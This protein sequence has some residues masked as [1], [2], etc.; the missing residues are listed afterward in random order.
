MTADTA[1]TKLARMPQARLVDVARVSGVSIATVSRALNMPDLVSESTRSLIREAISSL[2]YVPNG[3]ART[4]AS[5]R[6]RTIG[7]IIPTIR[8]TTAAQTIESFER[9]LGA[10]GYSLL[11]AASESNSLRTFKSISVMIEKSVDAV[12]II[13]YLNDEKCYEAL[14]RKGIP[15]IVAGPEPERSDIPHVTYNHR[16]AALSI[17]DHLLEE[18]HRDFALILSPPAESVRLRERTEALKTR[19]SSLGLHLPDNRIV[20]VPGSTFA[21]GRE[22]LRF[23][24]QQGPF[25]TAIIASND[26]LAAGAVFECQQ[27]GIAVPQRVSIAG[28]GDA[29]V[30]SQMHPKLTTIRPPRAEIGELA[31]RFLLDKLAGKHPNLP[32]EL[33]VKFLTG[34][35]TGNVPGAR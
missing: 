23:I 22:G 14:Q 11:L 10:S 1:G 20:E 13:T 15:F 5:Q 2:N 21:C 26:Y 17:L 24:Q 25:P 32:T 33:A 35:S 31:A 6:S 12:F 7:A 3:A 18:G 8:N 16:A 19:L 9:V 34:N 29:D 28:Y 4:L 27:Q 30:A